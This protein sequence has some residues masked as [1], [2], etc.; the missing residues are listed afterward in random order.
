MKKIL[1]IIYIL[2]LTGCSINYRLEIN[3][4]DTFNEIVSFT[5]SNENLSKQNVNL[6]TAFNELVEHYKLHE[7]I[8]PG[9][10]VPN[11]FQRNE[12]NGTSSGALIMKNETLKQLDLSIYLNRFFDSIELEKENDVITLY[13]YSFNYEKLSDMLKEKNINA[14]T[15]KFRIKCPYKVKSTNSTY[16]NEDTNEYIWELTKD[17]SIK[18]KYTTSEK[19]TQTIKDDESVLD[20][21]ISKI[22]YFATGIEK[23]QEN[24]K[25][26]KKYSRI[27]F[28]GIILVIV[29]IVILVIR[30]RINKRDQI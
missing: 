6:D 28:F 12:N 11:N 8:Y 14:N 5:D 19:N 23:N 2:L 10:K 20:K 25:K 29:L 17:T 7:G 9:I 13:F 16:Y 26:V 15:I 22:F 1:L 27:S 24:D 18:F 30:K 21:T 4:D 3:E